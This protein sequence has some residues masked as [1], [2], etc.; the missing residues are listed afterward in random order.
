[1]N[2]NPLP[3]A[4]LFQDNDILVLNKPAGLVVDRSASQ[5]AGTLQDWLECQFPHQKS[6]QRSGIVHRLDKETSGLLLVAR[7]EMARVH[8]IEQFSSR[9]IQKVYVALLHG[10][11]ER[12]R[13]VEGAIGRNPKN[14]EKFTVLS[15]GKDAITMFRPTKHFSFP[16]EKLKE[17]GIR[18]KPAFASEYANVTL[19]EAFPKTGRTHQIRVH[20]QSIGHPVISDERYAGRKRSRIDRKW[21]PRLFLHASTLTFLHPKTGE[22]MTFSADLPDILTFSLSILLSK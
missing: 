12:E 13:T 15:D 7:N 8:L 1:M 6:I 22:T 4:I 21:C 16:L 14:R 5:T 9:A 17:W 19:V 18:L 11:L 3:P 2:L 10:Q 20:A